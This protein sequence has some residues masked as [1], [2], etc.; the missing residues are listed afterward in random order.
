MDSDE[1]NSG[2]G[3]D[4]RPLGVSH[5]LDH[6]DC[7]ENADDGYPLHDVENDTCM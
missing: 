2:A 1:W 7:A 3:P 5:A 4:V 6:D